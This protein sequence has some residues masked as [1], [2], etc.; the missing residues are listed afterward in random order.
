MRPASVAFLFG[1]VCLSCGA[2]SPSAQALGTVRFKGSPANADLVVDERSI[3]P[4]NMFE[5]SG[6]LL[7]AGS[8][9]VVLRAAGYFTEYRIVDVAPQTVSQIEITLRPVPE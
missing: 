7:K 4:V 5:T 2:R 6:I 8:H 3:G 1:G 9:R